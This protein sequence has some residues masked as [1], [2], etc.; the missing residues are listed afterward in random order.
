MN[1]SWNQVASHDYGITR[2]KEAKSPVLIQKEALLRLFW[3]QRI[4]TGSYYEEILTSFYNTTSEE[5]SPVTQV[6]YTDKITDDY[7]ELSFLEPSFSFIIVLIGL[8]IT[9]ILFKKTLCTRW[10]QRDK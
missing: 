5:W 3:D 2:S 6:T 8:V 9:A 4:V 10:T 7:K 1:N